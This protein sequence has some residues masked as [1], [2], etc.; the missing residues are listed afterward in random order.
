MTDETLLLRLRAETLQTNLSRL[1]DH[2]ATPERMEDLRR[3]AETAEAVRKSVALSE[4]ARLAL[5][6]KI[7]RGEPISWD[8]KMD[9]EEQVGAEDAMTVETTF[10][11]M[12]LDL[13]EAR[14]GLLSLQRAI[15]QMKAKCFRVAETPVGAE[16][17]EG[18]RTSTK[19][20]IAELENIK[21]LGTNP[22]DL[23]RGWATLRGKVT[24]ETEPIFT[25]YMELLGAAALRDTG[26]DEKIS[27]L[28]DELLRSTG[29]KLLALPMRRQALVTTFKQVIRVTF[30]DWTVWALPSA[31]LEFWNVVGRQKVEGTLE[32]NLRNLPA[33]E[34]APIE[35]GHKQCL[36]DAYATYIMGPAYAYY[37]VGLLLAPDSEQD[38][39]RVRAI[40]AMLG[41]M[42]TEES[43]LIARYIR[44]R[45]QLLSAW[46]A[47][48]TQLGQSILNLDIDNADDADR[49]DPDGTGVRAL[50]RSFWKTLES[51]TSA[52]F[53]VAIW[54][55][56][57]PWAD[58]L[59]RDKAEQVKVPN[60]VELRHVLNAAWLARVHPDRNLTDDLNAAVRKLQDKVQE[61]QE[62][63]GK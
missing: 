9:Q 33:S 62:K 39:C 53:G 7:D 54:T 5:R 49:T 23:A 36:G 58:L 30:P 51:E 50:I 32:A 52:K 46:N 2:L 6:E 19:P 4:R 8:E 27:H 47:A 22:K 3:L 24:S 60:G 55:E 38:Q 44:V 25:D 41:Q 35:M 28:A 40:L 59:L 1:K 16:I 11:D 31:A 48:R 34:R 45:R 37:A 17:V 15:E 13:D 63:K 29:G 26:F 18:L 57:E 14:T 12:R 61:R 20:L 43:P 56:S 10:E 21:G 42:E